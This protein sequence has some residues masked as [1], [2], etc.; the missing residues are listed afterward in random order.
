MID[1]GAEP[2]QIGTFQSGDV[3]GRATIAEM[4][5]QAKQMTTRG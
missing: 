2:P 3:N 1:T 5:F 4:M